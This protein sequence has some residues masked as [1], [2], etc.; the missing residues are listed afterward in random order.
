MI[1][2]LLV[3]GA[4]IV[5]FLFGNSAEAL[6]GALTVI[7]FP[8]PSY[9]VEHFWTIEKFASPDKW[10]LFSGDTGTSVFMIRST[11]N[12]PVS[13]NYLVTGIIHIGNYDSVVPAVITGVVNEFSNG[14][15]S[16]IGCPVSFPYTLNPGKNILCAFSAALPDGI[17]RANTSTV[18][19]SGEVSGAAD[20]DIIDFTFV[21]PSVVNGSVTIKDSCP[22]A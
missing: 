15:H 1:K 14:V 20:S 6:E 9:Q 16:L 13:G 11:K 18:T 7:N 2:F 12:A 21:S 10:E 4:I 17:T 8:T 3:S 19:T 22:R 5:G